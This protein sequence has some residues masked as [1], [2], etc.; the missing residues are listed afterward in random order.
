MRTFLLGSLI[1]AVL[2]LSM[3][4]SESALSQDAPMVE[5]NEPIVLNDQ[6]TLLYYYFIYVDFED[7]TYLLGEIENTPD[8]AAAAPVLLFE[9]FDDQGFSFGSDA[10]SPLNAIVPAHGKMPFFSS[11]ILGKSVDFGDWTSVQVTSGSPY[12][13]V[14]QRDTSML[15]FVGVPDEGLI[16]NVGGV[17]AEIRNDGDSPLAELTLNVAFFDEQDRFI[18]MCGTGLGPIGLPPSKSAHFEMPDKYCEAFDTTILA[19]DIP[20][21]EQVTY[22]LIPVRWDT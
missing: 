14:P 10:I 12:S 1:V 18:G 7:T 19:L 4:Q 13:T 9:Y 3:A 21:D 11:Y 16:A 6:F 8:S 20:G 5:G 22:K 15:A 17:E 2:A